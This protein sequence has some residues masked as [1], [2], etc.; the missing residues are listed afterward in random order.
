MHF[1]KTSNLN[2]NSHS[3]FK[4]GHK[5]VIGLRTDLYNFGE[6]LITIVRAL[7]L[8]HVHHQLLDNLH[9]VLLSH[10]SIEKVQGP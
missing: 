8:V 1:F 10:H 4:V 9:E 6:K 2:L 5:L 3:P 7:S